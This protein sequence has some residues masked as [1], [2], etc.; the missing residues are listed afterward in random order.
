MQSS[1][2][3]AIVLLLAAL[4]ILGLSIHLALAQDANGYYITPDGGVTSWDS[5]GGYSSGPSGTA[6][7]NAQ[8]GYSVPTGGGYGSWTG[9]IQ[10]VVPSEPQTYVVPIVPDA[11]PQ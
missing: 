9:P 7:W 6:S 2:K 1:M 3:I 10:P 4:V 5:Q 8:G 11:L